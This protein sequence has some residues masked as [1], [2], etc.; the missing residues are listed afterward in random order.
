MYMIYMKNILNSSFDDFLIKVVFPDL[1]FFTTLSL[2]CRKGYVMTIFFYYVATL[3]KRLC[4]DATL[5]E[6]LCND[7]FF[8]DYV[9]TLQKR[10]CNDE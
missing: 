2:H 1:F 9:A 4:N 7:D 5:Q 10:L 3:Q 8:F 6:R